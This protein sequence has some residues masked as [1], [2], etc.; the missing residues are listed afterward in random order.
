MRGV[1]SGI[2]E[3]GNFFFVGG[4]VVYFSSNLKGGGVGGYREI[5]IG[6]F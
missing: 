2:D 6:R 3:S 4:C 5:V 1:T